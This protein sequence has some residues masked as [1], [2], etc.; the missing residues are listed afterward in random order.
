MAQGAMTVAVEADL[1]GNDGQGRRLALRTIHA[2]TSGA[3]KNQKMQKQ[4]SK[5]KLTLI[6]Y[7]LVFQQQI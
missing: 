7:V 2:G 1:G 4:Q 5:E 6:F 3:K